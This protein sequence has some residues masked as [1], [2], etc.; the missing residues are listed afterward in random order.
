MNI[1]KVLNNIQLMVLKNIQ[2]I[3]HLISIILKND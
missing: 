2:L 3:K 1:L